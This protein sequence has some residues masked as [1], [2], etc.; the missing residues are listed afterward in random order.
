MIALALVG[1]AAAVT[2]EAV[3]REPTLERYHGACGG[4]AAIGGDAWNRDVDSLEATL[5]TWTITDIQAA[6]DH[7]ADDGS[8]GGRRFADVV[9]AALAAGQVDRREPPPMVEVIEDIRSFHPPSRHRAPP[10]WARAAGTVGLV[11]AVGGVSAAGYG[12]VARAEAGESLARGRGRGDADDTRAAHRA[13]GA[14]NV[15]LL[16][17]TAAAVLGG[18]TLVVGWGVRW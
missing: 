18:A 14:A 10:P 2:P 6:I 9:P 3:L 15:T 1:L 11:V 16:T 12:G 17:G 7:V 4:S 13:L 8:C 5:L